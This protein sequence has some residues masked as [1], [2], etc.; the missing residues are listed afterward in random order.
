MFFITPKVKASNTA[1]IGELLTALDKAIK[2][3][4]EFTKNKLYAEYFG[5][6]AVAV[7][8][9]VQIK[10]DVQLTV[11]ITLIGL[12]L[13]ISF[14]FKR[15]EVFFLIFIPVLFGG[16]FS[17]ALLYLIKGE[18]S[19]IAGHAYSTQR[20]WINQAGSRNT[21]VGIAISN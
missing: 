20:S 10:K 12:F 13:F 15:L 6:A 11:S 5:S 14:F 8:N 21:S 18:V 17:L 19:G 9:A 7:G 16:A 2:N 1:K 4:I 3:N